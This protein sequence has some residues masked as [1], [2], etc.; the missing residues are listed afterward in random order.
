MRSSTGE[1]PRGGGSPCAAR[2]LASVLEAA[3]ETPSDD[4]NNN[5]SAFG[6][7]SGAGA[8]ADAPTPP[9]SEFLARPERRLN[10]VLDLGDL[11]EIHPEIHPEIAAAGDPHSNRIGAAAEP[12]YAEIGARSAEII[13]VAVDGTTPPR[14]DG[15][16]DGGGCDERVSEDEVTPPPPIAPTQPGAPA[17][18]TM[19]MTNV[20]V[21]L[22]DRLLLR[23]KE[24]QE[25]RRLLQACR[26]DVP[27]TARRRDPHP[28]VWGGV[29]TLREIAGDR[30][31]SREGVY[32]HLAGD[33]GRSREGV[34]PDPLAM[35][36]ARAGEISCRAAGGGGG[37]GGAAG[38][39]TTTLTP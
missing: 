31:R 11:P 4:N 23:Q 30:G 7:C 19:T 21:P 6:G 22:G 34:Y 12:R 5:N 35:S 10:Y 20:T 13:G 15:D 38:A 32:P 1:I 26:R 29:L 33:R 3:V 39:P 28:H 27:T 24:R 14:A 36:A 9:L 18:P 2:A 37:G 8:D 25:K 17:G 16:G